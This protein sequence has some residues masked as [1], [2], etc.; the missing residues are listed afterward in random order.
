MNYDHAEICRTLKVL[1]PP[2]DVA[3]LRILN[4]G[5][6]G[7]VSGYYNDLDKLAAD[8]AEWSGTG[9]GIYATLNPVDRALLA[10]S[11]NRLRPRAKDTTADTNIL[12]RYWLLLDFDPRRPS[13]ISSTEDE[14]AAALAIARRCYDFLIALGFPPDSLIL[15]DS[16]NGAHILIR[17]DLPNDDAATRLVKRCLEAVALRFDD[18]TVAVDRGV[19]NAARISKIYGTLACK[20][21]S[22]PD[23][24]HRLAKLLIVPEVVNPAPIAMLEKQAAL[25]PEE[26]KKEQTF[27]NSGGK[28]FDL[29]RWIADNEL[30]VDG[31]LSWDGGEKW[32]FRTCPWNPDH[33]NRSAFIIRRA[34]PTS[35]I[36]C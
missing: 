1:F 27:R 33:T 34:S 15:A 24:P 26:R 25:A 9:M 11:L 28:Q 23:R 35:R 5:T 6:N 22:T 31:P 20:G 21:D 17:V 16:G 4:A 2:G 29:A 3:E 7:T 32:V 13:G 10:R 30:D 12:R 36:R 14:H 19:Y 8:A 18:E